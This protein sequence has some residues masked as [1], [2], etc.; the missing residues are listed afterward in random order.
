MAKNMMMRTLLP[1]QKLGQVMTKM[2]MGVTV[3]TKTVI[4]C[5]DSVYQ[6]IKFLMRTVLF[7]ITV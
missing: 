2:M 5:S 7:D 1:A 6:F 4:T 3:M